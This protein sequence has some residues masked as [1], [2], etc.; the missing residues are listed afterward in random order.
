MDETA[1]IRSEV[2]KFMERE[3]LTLS[4]LGRKTGLNVGSLSSIITGRRTMSVNQLDRITG[5]M[6]LPE[7]HFYEL[8]IQDN[9]TATQPNWRRLRPFIFRCADLDKL[10][11]IY[12]TVSWLL[13]NLVYCPILFDAAE[14]LL[15]E[16]KKDAAA[17]LYEG[18]AVTEHSQ[19]SE[20]LALCQYRLFTIRVGND[21]AQNLHAA[22][23]FEPYAERLDEVLQ[24]DALKD[25]AN[26]YRSLR[27]WDRV[28]KFAEQ[29]DILARIH[30]FADSRQHRRGEDPYA[31][32]SRPLFV[33]IAYSDLLR[34]EVCHEREDFEQALQFISKYTDLSWVKENCAEVLHWKEQFQEW[35]T[36][37]AY[38][39]KLFSGDLSVLPQYVVHIKTIKDDVLLSLL[40]ITDLAN[41]FNI[42]VDEVF[43]HFKSEIQ[44][45][46]EEK[47]A[48]GSYYDNRLKAERLTR[49][50]S[51]LS[52]Y[53]LQKGEIQVGFK[54]LL[55]SLAKSA[56]I[57]VD[58]NIGKRVG[59]LGTPQ[60]KAFKEG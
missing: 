10:D 1:T 17:I 58:H 38:S 30:Y 31:K 25:L 55:E 59:L 15:Q 53:Y 57:I 4:D 2:E 21:Q 27:K 40:N 3:K 8:Y 36:T 51:E 39:T 52:E 47:N 42:N 41:R 23:R 33:Y 35:A 7:G 13:D 29:M 34:G 16:G 22:A 19:H 14:E 50:F 44:Y 56:S 49:L 28:D 37:N 46:T 60:N 5:L 18:V 43:E 45:L 9:M 6:G 48:P 24:L 32:L 12:Q 11:C 20:R 54:Y 26:V